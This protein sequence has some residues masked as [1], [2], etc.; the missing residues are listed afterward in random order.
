MPGRGKKHT[1]MTHMTEKKLGVDVQPSPGLQLLA[2]GQE[3]SD[4]PDREFILHGIKHG[5]DIMDT[6]AVISNVSSDNY[7]SARPSSALHN[8]P[9][10]QVLKEVALGNYDICDAP[11]EIISPLGVL[12]KPD[13]D[14]RLIHDCSR[15]IGSAV[16]DYCSTDW[17]QTFSTVE[18]AASRMTKGCYF[19][20]VDFKSA[21]RSVGISQQSQ[22]VT[23]LKWQFN[24]QTVYM[25]DTKLCFGA[26]LSPGMF[27]R[28]NQAVKRMM[29][30]TGYDLIVV[31][32]DDFLI[33]SESK[34]EREIA[35]SILIL[36]LR[37]LV[38]SIHRVK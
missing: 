8:K 38:F 3:L 10:E 15:P 22:M 2:R 13:G 17:Q 25:R 5:F 35:L 9:S 7:P 6:D 14:V 19:A 32:L 24:G 30:R 23:G 33:I 18:D 11:P 20:N 29:A 34:V 37:R 4:G 27:H 12:P 31:Y 26:K 28:L 1:V 16:N 36:L 21:Y